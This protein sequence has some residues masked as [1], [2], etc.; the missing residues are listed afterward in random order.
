MLPSFSDL[1]VQLPLRYWTEIQTDRELPPL[2]IFSGGGTG[3]NG[4]SCEKTKKR[5]SGGANPKKFAS[6]PTL[7]SDVQRPLGRVG[8]RGVRPRGSAEFPLEQRD[9]AITLKLAGK[10]GAV[11]YIAM[12]RESGD[13]RTGFQAHRTGSFRVVMANSFRFAAAG[14]W[15]L[16]GVAGLSVSLKAQFLEDV[17]LAEVPDYA[18]YAGCFGTAAGN[19]MGYWD[20]HGF[21]NFYTGPTDDGLAPLNS[22]LGN[23]G[24]RSMW[25]SKAGFDGRPEDQ[26][27]HLDDYWENFEFAS[28]FESTAED[29]YVLA[30]RPEHEPDCLGDF[31]GQSQNKWSDLGGECSGNINGYAFVFWDAEGA[32]RENFQ[33]LA[34]NGEPVRDIPSGLKEW[35]K[36]R[37]SDA[38]VASQLVDINP[39][40][41]AGRGFKFEDLKAEIDAGYPVL[42][43][44]Q[45]HDQL[46]RDLPGNSRANPLA[47]SMVAYGYLI[48]LD[49]QALVRYRTSWASGNNAFN[50]WEPG[51]WEI[52][53]PLRGVITYRP[54]PRIISVVRAN[55]M[56]NF[57]W[58][59]PNSLVRDN[60]AGTSRHAHQYVL[61][62]ADDLTGGNFV[63]VSEPTLEMTA[64]L[65]EETAPRGFYRVRLL[66]AE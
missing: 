31:M 40:T 10:T 58:E 6:E 62:R 51:A 35:S 15:L 37:G 26:P 20:R 29:P 44:L 42:L 13:F 55:G 14:R 39:A 5:G 66:E 38:N 36:F 1:E 64:S 3:K 18:W 47:H 50:P 19:L 25:A 11:V 52:N 7:S 60:L 28:T 54:M 8:S 46:S 2:F 16:A 41:P 27:G 49:G 53:L 23:A 63:A 9:R 48:T 33:P 43:I 4:G 22:N 65:A 32:R 61:E 34:Q 56:V 45:R 30:D 17:A 59:G 57:A 12:S 21:P 24:I